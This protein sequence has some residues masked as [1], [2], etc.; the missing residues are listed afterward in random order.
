MLFQEFLASL[1]DLKKSYRL[2]LHFGLFYFFLSGVFLIPLI[3]YMINRLFL[4]VDGG[5]LLNLDVFKIVLTR[6]GILFVGIFLVVFIINVFVLFGTYLILSHKKI[7]R[8]EVT[9]TEAVLTAMKALPRLLSFE[10]LYLVVFLVLLLPL[11]EIQLS[12]F[13]RRYVEVPPTLLSNLQ[14]VR[15]GQGL[16]TSA[17]ALLGYFILRWVFSF[18]EVFLRHTSMRKSFQHSAALTQG[19]KISI[20]V[21]FLLMNTLLFGGFLSILYGLG[22]IPGLLEIPVRRDFREYFVTLAGL[23]VF[24]YSQVILPVNIFFLTKLYYSRKRRLGFPLIK[25]LPTVKWQWLMEKE[26]MLRRKHPK[27]RSYLILFFA[28]AFLWNFFI[29]AQINEGFLY[30]GRRV[31]IAAHRGDAVNA[32]E[33]TLSA[34]ESALNHGA[35]IVEMDVQMTKDGVLVLHHDVSLLRM[36]GVPEPVSHYTY[37]ELLALEVGSSFAEAFQGEPIPTLEEALLLLKGRGEALLDVKVEFGRELVAEKILM[38]LEKLE[39]KEYAYI[40]S[41]DYDFLRVI[42]RKDQEVK[43]GQIMYAA[44]GRLETL[45]V[46]FYTVRMNMLTPNLIKRAHE[47]GRG[48]F[49]WVIETEEELKTVLQYD[50]DGVIVKDVA[51]VAAVLR[52]EEPLEEEKEERPLGVFDLQ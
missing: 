16:Y 17:L 32:P 29:S 52:V 51:M 38:L 21:Q 41:F 15:M 20:L 34:V 50:I 35:T 31:H 18:H 46:D 1:K 10:L 48:V 45:D 33:N 24:L 49:V 40:Q 23:S 5:V 22:Q 26:G 43:L 9:I 25:E 47:A 4:S 12:P 30:A 3:S 13:L 37:E 27:R 8:E 2:Y 11:V 28:T 14:E 39:M 6:R 19:K 7:F 42:R 36:A 44:L